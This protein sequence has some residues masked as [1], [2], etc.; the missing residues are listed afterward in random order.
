MISLFSVDGLLQKMFVKRNVL[1][2]NLNFHKRFGYKKQKWYTIELS[3]KLVA[4]YTYTSNISP[5]WS[6]LDYIWNIES[7][8]RS[9]KREVSYC[10]VH[11]CVSNIMEKGW[12][13]AYYSSFCDSSIPDTWRY[14]HVLVTLIVKQC[15]GNSNQKDPDH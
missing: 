15:K 3:Q 2:T 7:M 11:R 9:G 1:K 8:G 12:T 6:S 14:I 13:R 5:L 4:V 10:T